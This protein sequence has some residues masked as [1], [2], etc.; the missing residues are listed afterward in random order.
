M[1]Q[2]V[3]YVAADDLQGIGA[4]GIDLW[5]ILAQGFT[6]LLLF[7]I[8]KKFA[9]EKIVSKL[10]ERHQ[11]IDS[12]VRLGIKMEKEFEQLQKIIEQKL[13]E[14]RHDADGIL[15][16]AQQESGQIIKAAEEKAAHKVNQMLADAEAKITSDMEKAQQKLR[17]EL[18]ELVAAA[19]EEVIEQKLTSE[20]DM[21]LIKR[22]ISEVSR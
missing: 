7:L 19:T 18:V 21:R 2:F 6:F 17:A 15:D 8:V 12:G 16:D 10:Q 5:A 1:R 3:H 4:L 9:L 13:Q 20:Q 14:A 11:K 22:A